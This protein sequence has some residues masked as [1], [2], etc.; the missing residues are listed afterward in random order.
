MYD[1]SVT[2][3]PTVRP[4]WQDGGSQG[5]VV[6]WIWSGHR[7]HRADVCGQLLVV[8]RTTLPHYHPGPRAA[9]NSDMHACWLLNVSHCVPH[10]VCGDPLPRAT[11]TCS[12]CSG[13]VRPVSR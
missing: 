6:V 1:Y 3:S 5:C 9:V 11:W 7:P 13:A 12:G 8:H 10:C 2:Q 4:Q